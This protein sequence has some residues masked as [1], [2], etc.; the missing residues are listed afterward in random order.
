MAKEK[1]Q[2][3]AGKIVSTVFNVLIYVFFA[4]CVLALVL[5]IT[6]KR[7]ADGAVTV[8]GMQMRIVVSDSMA[9][10]P[11]TDVSDFEIGSIPLYSMVFIETVPEDE[12]EADAWYAELK[13][14][15][16]L[17]F[18]YVYVTQETITHRITHIAEKENGNGYIIDLE[19]DNKAA[20]ADTLTQTIDT[21]LAATSGNHVIGKV[22]GKSLLLGLLVS[23]IKK[24]VGI[25]FIII[26]PCTIIAIF[27]I[28]RLVSVL[29]EGKRK[30]EREEQQKREDELASMRQQ[31]ELLQQQAAQA[32]T[33]AP[34]PVILPE[35]G[36]EED[37]EDEDATPAEQPSVVEEPQKAEEPTSNAPDADAS[38]TT[39]A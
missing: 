3:K 18:R 4:I 31:L 8:F 17:T 36:D 5:S 37:K 13:E 14:H 10:C 7:D 1:Q 15:D 30:R 34:S 6:S 33:P 28:F 32:T 35:D 22:V 2:T 29:T 21:S 19:G 26:V 25:I 38:D 11:E 23:V 9:E 39:E 24:P 20:D 27:E 16:V 12:A